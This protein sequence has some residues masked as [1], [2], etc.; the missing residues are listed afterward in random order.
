MSSVPR[1]ENT[2]FKQKNWVR[3]IL[4]KYSTHVLAF[5]AVQ[6]LKHEDISLSS[7]ES[8]IFCQFHNE[9]SEADQKI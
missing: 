4:F 7:V 2:R 6:T 8:I 1:D 5:N 3:E 9:H